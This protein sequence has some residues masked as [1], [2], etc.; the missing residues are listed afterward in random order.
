M[1]LEKVYLVYFDNGEM[2]EWNKHTVVAV[3]LTKEKA[4]EFA[5]SSNE[6]EELKKPRPDGLSHDGWYYVEEVLI[7]Q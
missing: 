6:E 1:N 7:T 4:D 2:D 5:K 3:C